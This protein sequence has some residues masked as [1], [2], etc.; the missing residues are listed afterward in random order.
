MRGDAAGAR[1][2]FTG[3]RILT[4]DASCPQPEAVVVADGRIAAVGDRAAFASEGASIL[5]LDGRTLVPGLIDAH[6]HLSIAALH[7]RWRDAGGATSPADVLAAA[8]A[9]AEAE[10]DAAWIRVSGWGGPEVAPISR[11][12]LDELDLGRPIVVAHQSL[13]QA[14]VDS[15]G[16]AE[17]SIGRTTPQPAGGEIDHGPDGE[18]SGLLVERAWG[19]AHA[20]SMAAYADPD[21]WAEHI[22]A[23]ARQLLAE[24]ITA[25]H[26]AA[27]APAAEAVYATMARASA[28]PLSVLTLPHPASLFSHDFADR[29]DGPCTGE[30]D[31]ALRVGPAKLFADGGVAI[32]LDVTL[33]G[34]RIRSG[35]LMDDL[36][37]VARRATERGWRLAVHAIGNVGVDR[38]LAAFED[39]A[40]RQPGRDHRFRVEHALVTSPRQW[41]RL[42]ALDAIGVVQPGFVE[43]VGTQS[44]GVRFD[45]HH[46][47]A[48][49]G[50]AAA[51]V[52]LAGSSDDPCA[53]VPPLWCAH[54]GITRR[55][56]DGILLEP[57]QSLPFDAWLHAYTMGAALAG[58]QEAERGSLTPGKRADLV[59]LD[60]ALDGG[61]AP[62][63]M[64]TWVGGR[65]VAGS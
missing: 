64:S 7:P 17:L 23:R 61:A 30:G 60:G 48:C 21:R 58:G 11:R 28:L 18:P 10:P 44:G 42:G 31:D 27:C 57:D 41:R 37:A 35:I 9:Q 46:W 25:V 12:D 4:M 52:I 53:P 14:V 43:H 2:V 22:A 47:L 55:T 24:G 3:G 5:D 39:V 19:T 65:L 15:A 29:F 49:A 33:G 16:L 54:K 6:N 26:D 56:D 8:R 51:G 38:C 1:V 32:G 13:H 34:H 36:D 63:V 45:E 20:R 50:L 40:R 59:V 62:R